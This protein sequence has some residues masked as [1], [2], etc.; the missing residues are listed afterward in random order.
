MATPT[1][2]RELVLDAL[3]KG[4]NHGVYAYENTSR[5]LDTALEV[6]E[7]GDW[8]G[9]KPHHR[10]SFPAYRAGFLFG[11]ISCLDRDEKSAR[12]QYDRALEQF[13]VE[14]LELGL[15]TPE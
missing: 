14:A 8:E 3:E 10:T 6:A 11:F 1:E 2:T 7:D 13:G 5:C 12:E 15:I 9:H 4:F